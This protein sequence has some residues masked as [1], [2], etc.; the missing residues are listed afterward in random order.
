MVDDLNLL[1][2]LFIY[3][4][5]MQHSIVIRIDKP[6]NIIL[7]VHIIYFIIISCCVYLLEMGNLL[8]SSGLLGS[9]G[10]SSAL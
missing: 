6:I 4:I 9:H 1:L 2:L 7:H 8:F 10:E 3:C 5:I